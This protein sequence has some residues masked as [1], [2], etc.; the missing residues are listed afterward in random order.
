MRDASPASA[1]APASLG[2]ASSRDRRATARKV[3]LFLALA[4]PGLAIV[5]ASCGNGPTAAGQ[6]SSLVSEGVRAEATGHSQKALHDFRSAAAVDR[7]DAVPYY[8]I[9]VLYQRTLHDSALAAT[10]Y[11]RALSL[12]P[13]Y[14]SAMFDLAI[15]DT[16]SAPQDA[17]NLYNELL[18]RNPNDANVNFNLG[19]LLIVL[20]QPVPG[21]EALKKAVA[22]DPALARRLP[23]GITP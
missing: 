21:H 2:A 20:K 14:R 10:A 9:G 17:L 18:L 19:L 12:D 5:S 8:E 13:T 1:C 22:L 16:P 3:R 4:L 11:K 7:S 23:A 6:A 15:V